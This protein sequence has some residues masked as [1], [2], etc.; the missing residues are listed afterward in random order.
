MAIWVARGLKHPSSSCFEFQ[1]V[2]WDKNLRW[3]GMVPISVV[4]EVVARCGDDPRSR[5]FLEGLGWLPCVCV[6]KMP[7]SVLFLR[8]KIVSLPS[9]LR[10]SFYGKLFFMG[11]CSNQPS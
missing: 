6:R 4:F 5:M 10:V 8:E 2:S 7:T 3:Y 1:G 11:K 9:T